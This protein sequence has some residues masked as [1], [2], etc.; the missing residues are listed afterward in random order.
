VVLALAGAG[1]ALALTGDDGKPKADPSTGA[2]ET[3]SP[4]DS[5]TES[6]S[7]TETESPTTEPPDTGDYTPQDGDEE[8]AIAA[9]TE[10]FKGQ[11]GIDDATAAC[12]AEKLVGDLGIPRMVEA[13]ML[14]SDLEVNDDPMSGSLPADVQASVVSAGFDCALASIAP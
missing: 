7:E 8:K 12:V 2:T 13:G 10:A 1:V 11:E 3:D 14:T 5:P 9:V 6:P 4:T